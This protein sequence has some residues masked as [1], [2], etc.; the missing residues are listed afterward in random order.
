MRGI[1]SSDP[2]IHLFQSIFDAS[3]IHRSYTTHKHTHY[4]ADN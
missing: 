3:N 4:I 1:N 2:S